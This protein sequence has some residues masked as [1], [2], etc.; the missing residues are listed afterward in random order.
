MTRI[1]WIQTNDAA[2]ESIG[3]DRRTMARCDFVHIFRIFDTH[4]YCKLF[5][6]SVLKVSKW[7]KNICDN[8]TTICQIAIDWQLCLLQFFHRHT[9]QF[10]R[11]VRSKKANVRIFRCWYVFLNSRTCY[12][13]SIAWQTVYETNSSRKKTSSSFELNHRNLFCVMFTCRIY[14]VFSLINYCLQ[15]DDYLKLNP[16]RTVFSVA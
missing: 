11:M 14:V 8:T 10:H 16:R 15:S 13:V 12:I 9:H 4:C 6:Y 5:K 2:F 7:M 3:L 1:C